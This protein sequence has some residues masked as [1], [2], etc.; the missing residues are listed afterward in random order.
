MKLFE[1]MASGTP[2]VASDLPSIREIVSDEDV[3]FVAPNDARA[4]AEMINYV[5]AHP[6]QGKGKAERARTLVAGYTWEGRAT[7]ILAF[8]RR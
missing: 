7:D 1:Y 3:F 5:L 6:D 4:L 8:M 2:I